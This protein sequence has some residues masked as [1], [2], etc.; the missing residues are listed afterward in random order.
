MLHLKRFFS[1]TPVNVYVYMFIRLYVY[2]FIC[3]EDSDEYGLL[4][5]YASD[6]NIIEYD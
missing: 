4:V 5:W 3:L 2:T 1:L 6:I